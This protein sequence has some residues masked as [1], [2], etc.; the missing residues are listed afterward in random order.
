VA[1]KCKVVKPADSKS[2]KDLVTDDKVTESKDQ[3]Q[4]SSEEKNPQY[5]IRRSK[6]I[7]EKKHK[8]WSDKYHLKKPL[9]DE[10]V[11]LE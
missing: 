2:D 4:E 7:Y 10:F 6:R 9:E 3:T 1:D 8:G 5:E 11:K